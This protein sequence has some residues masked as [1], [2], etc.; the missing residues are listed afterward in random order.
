VGRYGTGWKVH[1]GAPPEDGKANTAVVRLLADAL[2]VAARDV[3]IVSGHTSRDKTVA[4]AGID[5]DET[6]RRLARASRGGRDT[7]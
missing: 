4:L 6:E 7:A 3:E 5:P 2:G 1:V